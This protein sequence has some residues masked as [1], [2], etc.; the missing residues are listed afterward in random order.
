MKK[1]VMI[2]LGMLIC[3][4]GYSL[5]CGVMNNAFEGTTVADRS[6]ITNSTQIHVRGIIDGFVGGVRTATS[7]LMDDGESVKMTLYMSNKL[8]NYSTEVITDMVKDY[9]KK[10]PTDTQ[11]TATM[12]IIQNIITDTSPIIEKHKKVN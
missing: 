9:C 11:W 8:N 7:L 3:N 5:D 12:N 4:V 1:V 10:Y 6:S 2:I